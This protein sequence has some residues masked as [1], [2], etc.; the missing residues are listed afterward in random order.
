MSRKGLSL[1]EKRKRMEAI[2]HETREFFQ[3]KELEKI[4]PKTKGIVMQSVK[5]VLQSL[6]DDN[7]VNGEKI[8]TSNY[9][10]SFPSTALQTRKRK[11]EDLTEELDILVKRNKEAERKIEEASAGREDSDSRA[12]KLARLA[13]AESLKE[14]NLKEL[15]KFRD[16]D[17]A[18]LETKAK[19]AD[20][21]KDAA[22]RWTENIFILQSYCCNK[23][24]IERSEFD[25]QFQIP[26]DFDTIP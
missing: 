22:N 19:A 1:E 25:K 23:F 2:F 21:A 18:L 11:I 20:I 13:E 6:V 7:L 10:W 14:T 24:N 12:E 16:C 8:G 9:F 26:E 4:A 3:L 5:D 17:P 15:Q